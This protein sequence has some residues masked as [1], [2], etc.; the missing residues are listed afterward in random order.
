MKN[1]QLI[2]AWNRMNPDEE[3]KMRILQQLQ[4]VSGTAAKH[5]SPRLLPKFTIGLA[6][7]LVVLTGSFGTVYAADASFRE[8]VRSL[9][10]PL[11][12]PD[13]IIQID[14][15]HM[16][17]SFDATDVLLSFLDK[18]NRAEFGNSVTALY[19]NGYHYSLFT[20][21]ENFLQAFVDSN[22]DGYCIM[23]SMERLDHGDTSGILQ[24]TSYRV[25][26]NSA[27][28]ALMS[29]LTPYSDVESEGTVSLTRDDAS[30][31]KG[32]EDSVVFYHVNDK[33]NVVSLALDGEDAR[34]LYDILT[35][36]DRHEDI[37][38]GLFQYVFKIG[39]VTYLF[40]SNGAGMID[41]AGAHEGFTL[42]EEE[43][44]AILGVLERYGIEG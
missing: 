12:G 25:L 29:E 32:M 16:T 11:Y 38:G 39:D 36:C 4:S 5:D 24:V 13:E 27:A 44:A 35:D 37:K 19:E 8:Y 30:I 7:I 33:K 21:D 9:L 1:D 28:E 3:T 10:F 23:V 22:M 41:E 31:I 20:Q 26:E 18:F 34:I 42:D 40:D 2:M 17:G 15:G 43:L 6:A 14:N